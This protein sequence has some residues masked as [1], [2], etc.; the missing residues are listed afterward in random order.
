MKIDLTKTNE[1]ELGIETYLAE[2]NGKCAVENNVP[3]G[4]NLQSSHF[5]L[6]QDILCAFLKFRLDMSGKL[7]KK[8]NQEKH[9]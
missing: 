6:W 7:T 1:S 5:S 3:S 2:K 4:E 8:R 9:D